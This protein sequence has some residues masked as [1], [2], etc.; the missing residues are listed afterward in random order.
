MNTSF[1]Q[2]SLIEY[3]TLSDT[4]FTLIKKCRGE[5][6][7]LGFAYQLIFIRLLN[8]A[9]RQSPFE[10]IEEIVIYAGMQ[11]SLDTSIIDLYS[12]RQKISAHQKIIIS[13][14]QCSVFNDHTQTLLKD[15]IFQQALQFEPISLLHIKSVGF[16]RDLK[17]LLPSEDTLLRI[18]RAQRFVA[19]QLLFDKIHT[20]LSPDIIN[21][22]DALLEVTSDYS[23][24]ADLKSPVKNASP[25]TVLNLIERSECII[26]TGALQV[27]LEHVNNN[28]Q[29][30]LANEVKRC[31]ADR[32][33]KMEPTRRY[34]ALVCFLKQAHQNNTDLL[35]SSY[36]KL[37]NA[38][39]TRSETQVEKK[40]KQNEAMIRKS[41]ENYEEIKVVIRDKTI[42]DAQLRL[43]LYDRF[44]D[45]LE[46][47]LPEMHALLKGEKIQIFKAF[48]DK[49][50]YFRQFTPKLFTL[51]ALQAESTNTESN[52]L[53][54]LDVLTQ[55]NKDNKRTL[56]NNVP[57]GFIPKSLKKVVVNGKDD[58]DRRAWECALYL[59][60]R[61]EI[62]QGNINA[63]QSK[64]YSSIK[65][66]FITNDDMKLIAESFF[67]RSGFP[68]DRSQ[69]REYFTKRLSKAYKEYFNRE[70]E[71]EYAKVVNGKWT[72]GTDPA[73]IFS[74][75]RKKELDAM[76]SWLNKRMRF[77]KLPALLIEVDNDIH[78]TEALTL[79]GEN[80][81]SSIDSI[82]GV[83]AT[84]MAHGCNIGSYTMSKLIEGITYKE[85]CRIT[86]W[87]FTNDSMR[88]ALSWIINAM[89]KLGITKQW[90][91]G[92]TSSSDAHLKTF[93]QKV[94]EQSYQA[95]IGDF[96]LAFYT[97]VADNYAPFHSKPFDCAEGEAPH[98]LDGFLY[99][100]SD[101]PLE[102]HYTDTRA[103]AT[104][105]FSAFAWYG[106]KYSP[107]IRGIKNHNIYMIDPEMDYGNLSP[108]LKHKEAQINLSYIENNWEEMAQFYAS[109][110]QGNVTASVA[111]RRLLSLSKKNT[112]YKA[113]LYLGRILKTEHILAHMSDQEYRKS[114]HRGLLKGE[115]VHQLA[116]DIN[117]AN[118][119]KVTARE[120]KGQVISCNCLTM[121]MACI[122]YW[123][124]KELDRLVNLAEFSEMGFD[125][126]LVKHISPVGWDNVV[127]YGE[128]IINKRLIYR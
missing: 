80:G 76:K 51:L 1:S 92:K 53:K 125:L 21:K 48:T 16:L 85:I 13:H 38:A 12:S 117:Y 61:D 35:I 123:Q 42:P 95:R 30:T 6:N 93:N 50:S 34:T 127:L 45:E 115:E 66:F 114:K 26:A 71:N 110:E 120:P 77:I 87:Q 47:D 105:T 39:H 2:Y 19:R 8:R 75:E 24:I 79:P 74:P 43:V 94:S 11:L 78:F 14:L 25:D 70:P 119:G 88:V 44:P 90:G 104:I 73:E 113:N 4:D 28:Y 86:D 98:A 41:L 5:S 99:N 82:F 96:A 91:T 106:R 40:F 83:L 121:I 31:S 9:P 97:F 112:F 128:Y 63:S 7:K 10:I 64:R 55:L 62:K 20:C 27:N 60:V 103:A 69:V 108:L 54:A 37:I 81:S 23:P 122:I 102:E 33:K 118:R 107:R 49:Y 84:L 72:L 56:P 58:I 32:I 124:A 59:K 46:M 100:E 29:R 101:L 116:R 89:S 3:G 109:I 18:V 111:L 57:L 22:L 67:K 15:F 17:I 126:N 65:N 52:T 36:I 68:E